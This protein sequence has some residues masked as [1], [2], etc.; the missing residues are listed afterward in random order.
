[1]TYKACYGRREAAG[2]GCGFGSILDG[3][4]AKGEKDEEPTESGPERCGCGCGVEEVEAA[5]NSHLKERVG[6]VGCLG[7][8]RSTGCCVANACSVVRCECIFLLALL[9]FIS[10]GPGSRINTRKGREIE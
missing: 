9:G 10:S 1:M 6:A 7:R 8:G 4:R 3:Q 5:I 2:G